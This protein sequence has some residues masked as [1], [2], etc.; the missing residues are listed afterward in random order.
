VA[1]APRSPEGDA[2][3]TAFQAGKFDEA[4][5]SFEAA[6]KK[7]PKDFGSLYNLGQTCQNLGDKNCAEDSYRK[8]LDIQPDLELAAAFLSA[9]LTDAGRLDDALAVAKKSLAKHPNSGALHESLGLALAAQGQQD[10]ASKEFSQALQISPNEPMFH[11][12]FARALNAWHVRGATPH[13]DAA[14]GLVKDDYVMIDSIGHEYRLAG[15]FDTCVKT[16]DRL[17][18][19]KDGGEVRTER[20]LCKLGQKDEKGAFDDFNAAVA[21]EPTYATAH[22]YLGGR[23]AKANKFKEAAA[24]YAKYLALAPDGS[25]A[26]QAA[27]RKKAAEEAAKKQK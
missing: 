6:I 13:L 3:L 8:A 25:L 1:D 5:T 22:Y 20:G 17:I 26:K 4:R 24:E 9:L 11:Y 15:E 16:F 12:N 19:M 7:N 18:H 27:D 2:G 14:L 10:L 23:L 21:A